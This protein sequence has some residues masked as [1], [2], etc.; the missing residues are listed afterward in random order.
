MRYWL[1]R[2]TGGETALGFAHPL[3]FTHHYLSIG[4]SDFS[5]DAFVRQVQTEGETAL[6]PNNFGI[7]VRKSGYLIVLC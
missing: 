6:H 4:W 5:S 2:I 1:H 7:I 3:L